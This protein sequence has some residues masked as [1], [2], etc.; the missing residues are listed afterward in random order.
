MLHLPSPTATLAVTAFVREHPC[1]TAFWDKRHGLWRVTQDDPDSDLRRAHRRRR[2]HR[3][4]GSP[5][6]TKPRHS[7]L[8]GYRTH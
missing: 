2:G 6:L 8:I 4:H 1:W 3:I 5:R 7:Q